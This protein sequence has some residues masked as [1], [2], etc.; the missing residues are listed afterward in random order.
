M[1]KRSLRKLLLGLIIAL[2]VIILVST[3]TLFFLGRSLPTR[4][5]MLNRQVTQSTKIYDR[6]GQILLYEISGGEK[7]TVVS[8][9]QIPQSLKDATV[10]LE[11]NQFYTEGAVNYTSILRALWVD[12]THIG[13]VQGGS[14]ITQQLAKNA[15]LTQE[16]TWTRKVKEFLLAIRLEQNYSKD[17][18]LEMYLNEIPYGA[19]VYG[20]E[21][22]SEAY[23]NKPVE[24][25]TLAESAVLASIPQAP[26]YYSPWGTHTQELISRQK[27][28][29]QKMYKDGKISEQQLNDALNTKV[30]F[31]PRKDRGILA[32][33]FV[34]AVQD[35]LDSRYGEDVVR[36]GGLKVITTLD[37]DMQKAAETA[38][39]E[40]AARNEKLYGGTNAALVAEDPK[41]GQILAMVGSRDYFDTQIEGNFNVATQGLRQPGS[42]LKPF[43]YMTAFEKGYTPDTVLFDTPTE[44]SNYS[45]CKLTPP[46][47]S[48][49]QCYH[50]QNFDNLF[51]GPV[52]MRNALDQSINVPAVKTLYLVGIN[53]ALNTLN[54]FGLKTLNAPNKYGLSLVLGG[55]AIRLIDL[56]GAYSG[57]AQ[58][59]VYHNQS[60]VLEV[61][62]PKGN[63]LE[64]Y[65]DKSQSV[66]D[67]NYVRM[68]DDVLSDANARA[69]LFGASTALTV[70]PGHDVGFKTGTSNDY[71]DAWSF[72][73]T[74]SLVVGVWA[75]N[76]DN[77]PLHKN[78]SSILAAV[79]MW[80]AFM[81]QVIQKDPGETFSKPEYTTPDKPVLRGDY[82]VDGQIHDILQW[83]N[84]N[85]PTGPYPANPQS[86]PEYN[87]WETGLQYWLSTNPIS[88][89]IS[90][91]NN[92]SSSTSPM[93]QIN[94]PA[95]G[96]FVGNAVN[97]NAIISSQNTIKTIRIYWNGGLIQE[98]NGSYGTNYNLTLS[99]TPP[100]T[101]SQ[102]VLTVE[103]VDQNNTVGNSFVLTH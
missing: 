2:L 8:L 44:F 74:P 36:G 11:D 60:M 21:S 68:I 50:P 12:V 42:S 65:E 1:T 86:D 23:F 20:V 39:A 76:N 16:R 100:N 5:Q 7:R 31:Q 87:N 77:S 18:I 30:V 43:V 69:P 64:S 25:L 67:S 32:P 46:F 99:F 28:T 72:G 102:N 66:F 4:D 88:I 96:S 79:P 90:I 47:T 103:A 101:Q 98:F 61:R 24:N 97:L 38:V 33:H 29:L 13:V 94:Q 83:V 85:D 55:G 95:T 15:F 91:P 17:Q 75:G 26:S 62:D 82:V 70:F 40:G 37:M 41:T 84:K 52:S 51:R 34:M 48:D 58:D 6:T 9:D 93:I 57:L 56:V 3:V 73:F 81:T 71:V 22:A 53:D 80:N 63:V 78:G 19:T 10:S 59:G 45:K 14:T 54:D 49:S 92:L 27:F 89:P 35:Y